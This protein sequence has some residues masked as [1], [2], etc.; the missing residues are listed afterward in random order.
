MRGGGKKKKKKKKK[1][2]V[3]A[4]VQKCMGGAAT[5]N[6]KTFSLVLN[7]LN[8]NHIAAWFDRIRVAGCN[9]DSPSR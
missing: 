7:T 8:S 1:K 2:K 9:D 6:A 4:T 5:K 3:G